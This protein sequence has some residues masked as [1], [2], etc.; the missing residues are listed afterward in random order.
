MPRHHYHQRTKK[1]QRVWEGEEH[2]NAILTEDAVKEMRLMRLDG[3][4]F[5]HIASEF[6]LPVSTVYAAVVGNSWRCVMDVAPVNDW[7]E[8]VPFED[9][10]GWEDEVLEDE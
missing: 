7:D 2:P 10:T 4:P 9:D 5:F 3:F 1:F 6:N 8:D